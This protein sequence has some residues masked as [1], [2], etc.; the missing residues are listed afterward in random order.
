MG[1]G[2]RS[3]PGEGGR[4]MI[5]EGPAD[6]D[7]GGEEERICRP[8]GIVGVGIEEEGDDGSEALRGERGGPDSGEELEKRNS[9]WARYQS[10]NFNL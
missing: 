2:V 8:R 1:E 6:G 5:G 7:E 10:L 3:G 4:V 9:L